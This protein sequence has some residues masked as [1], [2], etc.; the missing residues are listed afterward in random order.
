MCGIAGYVRAEGVADGATVEPMLDRLGHRGPDDRGVWAVAGVALG[1]TRLSILDLTSAGHQPMS[2][3]DGQGVLTYNGEV[4]NFP[5]LRRELEAEGI[6]FRSR[7]DS[8]VVLHA[9][10]RWGPERAVRRLDGMFAFAYHDRRNGGTWLARD[11]LGIKPLYYAETPGGIVFASEIKALFAHPAVPCRPDAMNVVTHVVRE[12]LDGAQ[13]PFDGVRSVLPGSLMQCRRSAEV[14]RYFDPMHDVDPHRILAGERDAF[15]DQSRRFD[16]TLRRSV[17]MH[18]VSDAPLAVMCSGGLDSGLVTAICRE[19]KPDLVA[20]VAD[21]EGAPESETTRAARVAAHLGVELRVVPVDGN[22]FFRLW[23]TAVYANDRPNFVPQNVAATAVAERVRADGVKVVLTGDGSDELFG[24]YSW[25]VTEYRAWRRRRL[26][27]A[28]IPNHR[29]LRALGRFLP[30]LGPNDLDALARRPFTR[31]SSAEQNAVADRLTCALTDRREIL[32]ESLFRRL[33][34]LPRHEDRAFIARSLQDL[35]IHLAECLDSNDRMAMSQSVELRVPFLENELIDFGLHLPRRAKY[36]HGR[37]KRLV[38]A[39]AMR[40]LPADVVSLPKIGF[41]VG[42]ELW[43]GM[44]GF[45]ADG[46]TAELLRWPR[47]YQ[48]DLLQ[49]I[50]RTPRFLF[51][52]LCLEIWARLFFAGATC[53]QLS[54]DLLR[55][56]PRVAR[57]APVR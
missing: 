47:A 17:H 51:R 49:R 25:Y 32:Q 46:V 24:G 44:E 1:H 40:E 26:R 13:T 2:T 20:Y 11:R 31:S 41:D 6:G 15:E 37:S 5:E 42:N 36:D 21:V 43:R 48:A 16:S 57:S 8:E 52:M 54:E 14:A 35:Y 10:H 23:P 39:M 56:R 7:T 55:H 9:L 3:P 27:A 34:V 19:R 38:H 4:Y 29:W 18:L 30:R 50:R 45:L 12:R 28:L 22:V 33:D 53:E